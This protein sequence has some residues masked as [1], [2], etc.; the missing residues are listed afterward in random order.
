MAQSELVTDTLVQ[1]V[2]PP[3]PACHQADGRTYRTRVSFE[4]TTESVGDL[5]FRNGISEWRIG[6]RSLFQQAPYTCR[7]EDGT[8][9]AEF[10]LETRSQGKRQVEVML[11]DS[12]LKGHYVWLKE[13]QS[14]LRFMMKGRLTEAAKNP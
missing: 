5:R 13:G 4:G 6:N 11:Q 10:E 8:L 3:P 1:E 9:V 12:T 14:P 2:M 7:T